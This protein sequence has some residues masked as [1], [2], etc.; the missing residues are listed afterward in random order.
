MPFIRTFIAFARFSLVML[1]VITLLAGAVCLQSM[2][3]AKSGHTPSLFQK[4]VEKHQPQLLADVKKLKTQSHINK[5]MI[6]E[7][8]RQ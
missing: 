1:S 6:D 8:L 2:Q 3:Q 4:Y 7:L 5:E